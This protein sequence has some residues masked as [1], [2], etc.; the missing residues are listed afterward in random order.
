MPID[1]VN[2]AFIS[3]LTAANA[4]GGL[5][6]DV[7]ALKT[8]LKALLKLSDDLSS[9]SSM[10]ADEKKILVQSLQMQIQL[11]MQQIAKLEAQGKK[12]ATAAD[13]K[14]PSADQAKN[15]PAGANDAPS[16][17]GA[18]IDTLV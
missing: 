7:A 18:I 5:A 13:T 3:R 17:N 6:S 4:A 15:V 2:T 12:G 14:A 16:L 1:S 10:S 11:I 8:R 9:D